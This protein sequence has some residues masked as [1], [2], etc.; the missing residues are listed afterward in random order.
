MRRELVVRR[1]LETIFHQ[2]LLLLLLI[3]PV[4]GVAVAY[5]STP[6]MYQTTATVW[7]LHRVE[8]I[9]ATGP[10]TNLE[11]TPAD[12]QSAYLT[13]LLQTQAFSLAVAKQ[14]NVVS[15]LNLSSGTLADPQHLD[16]AVS[17]EISKHVL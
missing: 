5:F 10:E 16:Q 7:A 2:P 6:R 12:T 17:A 8:I 11:A 9:G 1:T 14:S 4:V 15:T 3:L 13:E